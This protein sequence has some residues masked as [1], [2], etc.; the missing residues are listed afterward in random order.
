MSYRERQKLNVVSHVCVVRVGKVLDILNP[1]IQFEFL[2]R[3]PTG[4]WSRP[5]AF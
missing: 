1:D 5:E 3:W 2:P 4:W